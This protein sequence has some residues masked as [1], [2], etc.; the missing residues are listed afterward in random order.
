MKDD[1]MTK[2]PKRLMGK[3]QILDLYAKN[4]I[5][6]SKIGQDFEIL[7]KFSENGQFIKMRL[8]NF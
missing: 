4:W 1:F 5:P 7:K 6:I 3:G 2:T 8:A